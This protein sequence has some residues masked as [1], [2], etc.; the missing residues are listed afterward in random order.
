MAGSRY[1][2]VDAGGA[3]VVPTYRW[4]TEA[5]VAVGALNVGMLLKFKTNGSPYAIATVGTHAIGTAT[6]I[7]GVAAGAGTQ[8]ASA[9]GFIDVFMPL[10]GVIY[11]GFASTAANIDTLSEL[12]AL[13]G[14]RV[15]QE[16]SA[17][18]D[19]GNWTIDENGTEGQ[20]NPFLL[21]GGDHT[22]QTLKF[23]IRHGATA[24]GDQDLA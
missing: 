11:E 15:P 10:S 18:T 2:I 13:L 24:L 16:V 1:K 22:V 17:T 21:V 19:A 14:D 5:N 9:D 6:A 4:Q 3:N 23:M 20:T 8:T 12:N 7:I